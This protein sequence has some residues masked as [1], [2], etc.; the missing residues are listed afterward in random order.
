MN[1]EIIP[2]TIKTVV[3]IDGVTAVFLGTDTK[4][5][6]IY[7]EPSSGEVITMYLNGSLK[8]RPSTHDLIGYLLASFGATLDYVVITGCK[9]RVYFARLH[10]TASNEIL[11]KKIVDIDVRPSDALALACQQGSPIFVT[12][13]LFEK[14][15]DMT[16]VLENLEAISES[17][18]AKDDQDEESEDT[19]EDSE[20]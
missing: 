11:E 2:L 15:E 16:S 5:F 17:L 19:D 7:M 1:Q 12:R 9:K 14:V 20:E 4:N 3:P 10:L 8:E 18:Q 13:K 6:V